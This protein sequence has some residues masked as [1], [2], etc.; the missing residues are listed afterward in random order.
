MAANNMPGTPDANN[1][2]INGGHADFAFNCPDG[3]PCGP[4]RYDDGIHVTADPSGQLYIHDD[5][6]SPWISAFSFSNFSP[7]NFLEHGFVDLFGGTLCGCVFS[8]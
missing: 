3:D 2:S 6:V 1:Y 4:G 5:T 7:V 8:Q